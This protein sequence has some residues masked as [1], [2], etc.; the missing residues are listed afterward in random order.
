MARKSIFDNLGDSLSDSTD[1]LLEPDFDGND[2]QAAKEEVMKSA[3]EIPISG[4]VEFKNH[5]YHVDE[6]TEDF[7]Q[8]VDSIK[9]NGIL[10]PILVR[11]ATKDSYE[12]ISGHRRVAAAK[13]AGFVNVP[14]IIRVLDDD[15]ATIA[16]VHSNFYREK[17]RTSEKAKAYRMCLE[18]ERHQGIKG[19]DAAELAGKDQDS[20]RQVY[21]YVRLSYLNEYY[22]QM[23]DDGVLAFNSGYELSFLDEAS[24]AALSD[25]ICDFDKVPSL[26][27]ALVLKKVFEEKKESLCYADIVS[28]LNEKKEE[29]KPSVKVTLNEKRLYEYFEP[30]TSVEM[31]QSVILELLEG[32]KSGKITLQSGDYADVK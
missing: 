12:I 22:L 14:V 11:P 20:K 2:K 24:L 7:Q 19:T 32:Y 3:M 4:L 27:Q 29:K 26:E 8:L 15:A 5:P 30:D 17:I 1:Y 6:E 23:I 18:A 28:T 21:R 31:M 16:M 9:E 25:Y 13:V 10:Y